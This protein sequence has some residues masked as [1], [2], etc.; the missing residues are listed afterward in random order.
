M[1]AHDHTMVRRGDYSRLSITNGWH[2]CL[3]EHKWTL[4]DQIELRK[5]FGI[6]KLTQHNE[7]EYLSEYIGE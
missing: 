3:N 5:S 1:I 6:Y 7:N 4:V 2:G